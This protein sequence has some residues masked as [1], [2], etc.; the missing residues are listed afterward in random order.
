[1]LT[2]LTVS[3]LQKLLDIASEY[4]D[5][6][7]L[8]F[9]PGKTS[10]VI[11]GKNPFSV[12]PVWKL[13]DT[14]LKIET[15]MKHLGTSLGDLNGSIHTETRIKAATKAFY[16]VQSAGIASPNVNSDIVMDVY[17]SCVNSVLHFGCCN[18]HINK[19]NTQTLDRYQG[20]LIKRLLGLSKWCHST[21]LLKAIGI[22]PL[23]IDIQLQS[24]ELL[25]KCVIDDSIANSFYCY[26]LDY[27]YFWKANTLINRCRVFANNRN[28]NMSA[29]ILDDMYARTAKRSIVS[30]YKSSQGK[31]GLLDTIRSL[32]SC[33]N[34]ELLNIFLKAF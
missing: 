17:K 10:C 11:F 34:N 23:S 20:R 28:I 16:G 30:A 3:G 4:I 7:G 19:T 13:D 14:V 15:S 31:N 1:M 25:K 18:I 27:D 2:S 29:F 6:H 24:L 26:L 21:P 32:L 9:N 33:G 12:S 22:M 5:N 8:K